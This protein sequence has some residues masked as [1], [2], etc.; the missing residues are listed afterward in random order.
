LLFSQAFLNAGFERHTK[1]QCFFRHKIT[2]ELLVA[3]GFKPSDEVGGTDVYKLTRA[4]TVIT[5]VFSGVDYL[6]TA[7]HVDDTQTTSP[8]DEYACLILKPITDRF[9]ST[10]APNSEAFLGREIKQ[11]PDGGVLIHMTKRIHTIAEKYHMLGCKRKYSPEITDETIRKVLPSAEEVKLG[12]HLPYRSLLGEL[13]FICVYCRTDALAAVVTM[14]QFAN[15]WSI[16]QYN[17]LVDIVRYLVTK[18]DTGI[19]YK[20]GELLSLTM[21]TD[22]GFANLANGRSLGGYVAQVCGGIL[23]A[24][25]KMTGRTG[26]S[27]YDT[28]LQ[29]ACRSVKSAVILTELLEFAGFPKAP[30]PYG[31][32]NQSA[33][34]FVTDR[35]KLNARNQYIETKYWY[36]YERIQENLIEPY[37]V[38]TA[39]NTS[40]GVSKILGRKLTERFVEL[41]GMR[42]LA[43]LNAEWAALGGV[44]RDDALGGVRVVPKARGQALENDDTSVSNSV[45]LPTRVITSES[46]FVVSPSSHFAARRR[47]RG[48][49]SRRN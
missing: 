9:K 19:Y 22:A 4:D 5:Y 12:R 26:T 27:T 28:E 18:P 25:S 35:P 29:V 1:D 33:I 10:T 36:I 24:S 2:K 20:G 47:A 40:D 46:G 15:G 31:V 11:F 41:N 13:I 23:A 17:A 38:N 49:T 39:D 42:S 3:A 7:L 14:S 6:L 44:R 34:K 37:Y 32:D 21:M 16:K 43:N 45:A 8:A 48:G 30:V